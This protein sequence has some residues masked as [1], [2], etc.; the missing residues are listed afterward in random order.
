MVPLKLTFNIEFDI[1]NTAE[2]LL[3]TLFTLDAIRSIITGIYIDGNLV[4]DRIIILKYYVFQILWMDTL[5]I[6]SYWIFSG[7]DLIKLFFLLR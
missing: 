6:Y 3:Y 7:N 4:L 5:T 2:L 1:L